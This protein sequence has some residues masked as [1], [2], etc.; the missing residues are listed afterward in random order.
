MGNETIDTTKE[1]GTRHIPALLWKYT[2][3]AVVTQI[4]ATVYNLVDSIFLG[5][6]ENGALILAALA[7]TLPIMNIIHAFGSL[8][9]AGAGARMSI[10]LGRKDVRWAEKILGNSMILT[11]FFGALF[12]SAGYLF[13]RPILGL[14]GASATTISLAQEYMDIVLP[15]MFLTT[16]TF[17]LSGLIRASG[18]ASKSMWIQVSGALLNIVLDYLF[19]VLLGW[20]IRGG[21]WATTISMAFSAL[22]AVMHFLNPKSFIRFKRHCWEPKMYIV[23]NIL[24]IGI[25]PFSMNV[26]ACAVVALLNHQLISYGG[27]LA[28]SAY[29]VVNRVSMI[30]FMIMMGVCQGM[31]PIAGYNYGAGQNLRL[32]HVYSLALKWN[33]GLGIVGMLLALIIPR[34][35]VMMMNDDPQLISIA[36]PAMRYL[37]VMAPLIGFTATNS[38]FFQSIDKP[39]IA[40][41]TSLSRQVIFLI[42]LM[43]LVPLIYISLG[44]DGLSGVWCSCTISDLLGATLS[45]LLLYSQRKVFVPGYVPPE[46][47]PRKERGPNGIINQQ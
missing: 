38:Q 27:D 42:P 16:L 41:V 13:M 3:P 25:S 1:L 6:V 18:Y 8:V 29:G 7:I 26:A 35:L 9:G 5:H 46:R 21:A 28:V 15:G 33:I 17:N 14:F 11:F 47:K 30:V 20:G 43:F 32:K 39:W 40:I 37:L 44:A 22:L 45:A 36:V 24:A 4:I 19:I 34:L 31:Q 2:L 23:K 12:V 10:V